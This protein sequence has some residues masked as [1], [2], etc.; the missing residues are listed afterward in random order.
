MNVPKTKAV[1]G[2]ALLFYSVIIILSYNRL[3][4]PSHNGVIIFYDGASEFLSFDLQK[5]K[6]FS[7]HWRFY[8]L[9]SSLIWRFRI[10]NICFDFLFLPVE[11]N[12][13]YSIFKIRHLQ[14][15]ELPRTLSVEIRHF[16][17]PKRIWPHCASAPLISA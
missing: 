5:K 11:N 8:V 17:T 2:C 14:N 1:V 6:K 10:L 7:K 13:K 12:N 3:R 9:G 4:Q 16:A 15:D